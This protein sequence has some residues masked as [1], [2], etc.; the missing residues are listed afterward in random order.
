MEMVFVMMRID[1]ICCPQVSKIERKANYQ[2]QGQK[3]KHD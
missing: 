1:G 3:Q 2:V